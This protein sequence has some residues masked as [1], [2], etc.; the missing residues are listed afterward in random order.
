MFFMPL[1]T[2]G[3]PP[4]GGPS[5]GM[6]FGPLILIII[7]FYLFIIRPQN[8]KQ[9]ETQKM[10]D[11]LKK[12]DKIITIGGIHG[13][14]S[15][16]KDKTVIIKVDDNCK[17]E[18]NRTAISTVLKSDAEL[19]K[20]AEAAAAAAEAKKAKRSKKSKSDKTEEAPVEETVVA[21]EKAEDSSEENK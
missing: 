10:L 20:E 14:V 15:S 3:T 12:G 5:M 9:K 7:I 17:I 1:L 19:A 4:V 2:T 8:K 11:A 16:V 13:V 18:F 6:T 21:E